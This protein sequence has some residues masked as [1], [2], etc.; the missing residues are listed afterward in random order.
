MEAYQP[1]PPTLRAL[2]KLHKPNN[3]I[4]P[5][6]DWCNAP[7]YN[8][9]K[10]LAK[11]LNEVIQ[12]PNSF[13]IRNTNTLIEDLQHIETDKNTRLCSFDITNMYTNI[14]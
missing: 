8:L 13:N 12:L 2:I 6:I 14:P 9:T 10:H 1:Q 3:P 5:I 11:L 4:R 7:D